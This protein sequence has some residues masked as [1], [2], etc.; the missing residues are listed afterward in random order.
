MT[1]CRPSVDSVPLGHQKAANRCRFATLKTDPMTEAIR[2][3]I[4]PRCQVDSG[5]EVVPMASRF[6]L[7]PAVSPTGAVQAP[8]DEPRELDTSP[9]PTK[10]VFE[11]DSCGKR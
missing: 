10:P 4:L 3:C 9:E 8:L 2:R 11:C 6:P 5:P 7:P 1:K